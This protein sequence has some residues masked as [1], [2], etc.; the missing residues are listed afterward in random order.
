ME[1]MMGRTICGVQ[2]FDMEPVYETVKDIELTVR[3]K[4]YVGKLYRRQGLAKY[5]DRQGVEHISDLTTILDAGPDGVSTT[6][7]VV[8]ETWPT[9]E[10]CAEGRRRLQEIVTQCMTRQGIW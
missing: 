6:F 7:N 9:K 1:T 3:K 5:I 10:E 2:C 8:P 4:P